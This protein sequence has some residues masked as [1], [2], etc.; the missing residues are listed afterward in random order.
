MKALIVAALL[1]ST[2]IACAQQSTPAPDATLKLSAE[3]QKNFREVCAMAMRNAAL[4]TETTYGVSAWC[5]NM[6]AKIVQAQQAP[7]TE[8][9]PE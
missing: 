1:T 5:V 9:K 8:K 6:N 7:P 4:P 2:T 3:D